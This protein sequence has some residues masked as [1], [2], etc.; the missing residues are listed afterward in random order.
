MMLLQPVEWH[1]VDD[2]G[3]FDKLD[4]GGFATTKSKQR[5]QETSKHKVATTAL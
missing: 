1:H 2:V 3:R 4:R 5:L